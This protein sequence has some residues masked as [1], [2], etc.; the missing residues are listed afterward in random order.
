MFQTSQFAQIASTELFQALYFIG[1]DG[2]R[3]GRGE[4]CEAIVYSI[5]ANGIFVYIPRYSSHTLSTYILTYILSVRYGIKGPVYLKNKNELVVATP[6]KDTTDG[7][8]QIVW[9]DGRIKYCLTFCI[10][11]FLSGTIT[12]TDHTITV[13]HTYGQYTLR[14]FDHI[15]VRVKVDQPHAHAPVIGLELVRCHALS[16]A[17]IKN[18]KVADKKQIK[19]EMVEVRR[20][21]ILYFNVII[22]L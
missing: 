22:L 21:S 11:P 15:L 5:R 10:S 3:E 1:H 7:T 19:R 12:S 2:D 20:F 17:E 13:T 9:K 8:S 6:D 14:L 18:D 16:L 4:N